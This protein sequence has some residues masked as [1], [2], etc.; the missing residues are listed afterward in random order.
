MESLESLTKI[1]AYLEYPRE[2]MGYSNTDGSLNVLGI[3]FFC[4]EISKL[5]QHEREELYTRTFD[6]GNHCSLDVGYVIFGEDYKRG[7][8][9]V[10][11]KDLYRRL[12]LSFGPE[13]DDYLPYVLMAVTKMP[14][15]EERNEL[16]HIILIPAIE[17]ML[18]SLDALDGNQKLYA[19]LLK[20]INQILI[21]NLKKV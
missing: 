18:A 17:K 4:D 7:E 12:N 20:R 1:S 8:F 2:K 21:E 10:G 19:I 15:G 14:E 11:L 9:L 5:N 3:Q 16:V 13:L 6:I